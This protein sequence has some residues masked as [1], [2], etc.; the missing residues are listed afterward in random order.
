LGD[1]DVKAIG[2]GRIGIDPNVSAVFY[3]PGG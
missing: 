3:G 2:V 1:G